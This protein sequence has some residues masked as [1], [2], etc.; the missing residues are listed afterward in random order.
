MGNPKKARK[1]EGSSPWITALISGG[2]GL[3]VIL[4]LT[5]I[6]PLLLLKA[7]NPD[8]LMLLSALLCVAVGGA[9]GGLIASRSSKGAEIA[10]ALITALVMLIP[11]L[12][13]S[14]LYKK[15]FSA[16][17]FVLV[18]VTLFASSILSALGVLRIGN[19]K[20]RSMKRLTKARK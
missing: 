5:L 1:P 12:V 19:D 3:L 14:F 9:V 10:S 2:I 6:A 15:G 11:M 20:K 16:V 4:A 8:G 7:E 17:G 18:A 13:I